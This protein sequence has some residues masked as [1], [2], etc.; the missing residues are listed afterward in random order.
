MKN[1]L[2]S[3]AFV[4]SVFTV[5]A[6]KEFYGKDIPASIKGST[7]AVVMDGSDRYNEQLRDAVNQ[8]WKYT[9]VEFIDEATFEQY[10]SN[11]S[12]SFF[13]VQSGQVNGY[14]TDFFTLAIGNRRKSEQP[15]ILKE[16]IV[17]TDKINKD[18]APMV[19]L[20]VQ[21]MQHYINGVE[22]G[23]ITDRTFSD[24]VISKETYRIKE[25][26][27]LA[28]EKDLEE[29]IRSQAKQKEFYPGEI[30][31]V[32]RERVNEAVLKNESVAV[33]DVILTGSR[34]NMYSYKRIYDAATGELLY[35]QDTE[36][37]HGKKQGLTDDD[38][39]SLHKAR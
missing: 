35:R 37:L 25:M 7:L 3:V 4:F 26:P 16:L 34:N 23:N 17:D 10:K 33:V 36:S 21:H 6:Q 12:Y 11:A 9:A 32:S 2:L 30:Q 13:F 22:S 14:D 18:G 1:L 8:H 27:L 15:L 29:S 38:L 19:H 31:T 20:Y 28:T 39:K 24:R 5:S